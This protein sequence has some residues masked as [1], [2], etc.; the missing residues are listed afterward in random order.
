VIARGGTHLAIDPF[1]ESSWG[2]AGLMALE[3]AGVR[4]HVEVIE[5]ESQLALPRLVSEGRSFDTAFVVGD[6]RFESALMDLC[7]MTPTRSA[8]SASRWTPA[9]SRTAFAG[10]PGDRDGGVPSGT[11]GLAVLRCPAQR[12]E[13]RWDA[14]VPPY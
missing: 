2:G 7:F 5:E 4:D 9:R 12:P 13:L 6:H 8:T 1:Q 14:F 10:G 11:G 3:E